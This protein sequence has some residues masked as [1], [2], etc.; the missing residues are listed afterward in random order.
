MLQTLSNI[1]LFFLSIALITSAIEIKRINYE[2]KQLK[3]FAVY[4]ECAVFTSTD[5]SGIKFN[6]EKPQILYNNK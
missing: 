6:H 5:F 1:M 4:N 2:N 3:V